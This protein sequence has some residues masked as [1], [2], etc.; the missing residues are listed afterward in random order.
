[1][2]NQGS[3]NCGVDVVVRVGTTK[4]SEPSKPPE[5]IFGYCPDKVA[6]RCSISD[7]GD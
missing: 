1:M 3:G 7:L 6:G 5:L 4:L 2:P